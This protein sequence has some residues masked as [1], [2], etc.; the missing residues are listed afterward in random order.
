MQNPYQKMVAAIVIAVAMQIAPSFAQDNF[1]QENI[2]RLK[3]Q[4]RSALKN[5]EQAKQFRLWQA[6]YRAYQETLR[7]EAM[8]WQS[9]SPARPTWNANPQF[10][11]PYDPLYGNGRTYV[12]MGRRMVY[13]NEYRAF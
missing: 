5:S 11:L 4:S 13:M 1:Q 10:L 3:S 8:L 9:N 7:E 2:E 12:P 6:Q